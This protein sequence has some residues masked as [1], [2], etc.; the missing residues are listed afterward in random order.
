MRDSHHRRLAILAVKE[1]ERV[2]PI[3]EQARPTDHRPRRAI[4]AIRA[5]ADGR[6]ELGMAE[7]RRL[8]LG[9]HAV[10]RATKADAARFA[11]RAAGHAVATWHVPTHA[12][13]APL[14]ACKAILASSSASWDKPGSS[15]T[16]QNKALV[17]RWIGFASKG[18]PGSFS[19]FIAR[20]YMGHLG[21]MDTDLAEL[22]R[23]ERAFA[24]AFQ[25]ARYAIEDLVAE[26][27]RVT[28]RI[29]TRGTHRGEFEG[30]APT[31][32][33]VEFTGMVQYRIAA[34]RIAESW[35]ELDLLRLMQQLRSPRRDATTCAT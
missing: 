21:G 2:P 29:T 10:A 27:D 11:A 4:E 22:E 18:F 33:R 3:F 32:R 28:A 23:A 35:G 30:I 9:A 7:V 17:R 14:Y 34:D 25:D 24:R 16:A 6:R 8:S 31:R 12:M 20:D 5:W 26:R 15:D 13:G 1:A 19:E